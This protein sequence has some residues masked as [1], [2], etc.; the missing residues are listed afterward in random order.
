MVRARLKMFRST[1]GY[2]RSNEKFAGRRYG[3]RLGEGFKRA[4]NLPKPIHSK[5]SAQPTEEVTG[6]FPTKSRRN[7]R[8]G[9]NIIVGVIDSYATAFSAVKVNVV[10]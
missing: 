5:I 4:D 2:R 8:G 10:D 6:A 3:S 7:L 1:A 9:P